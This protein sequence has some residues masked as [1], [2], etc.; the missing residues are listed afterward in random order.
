MKAI[1]YTRTKITYP[2]AR[3]VLE[4]I[5]EIFEESISKLFNYEMFVCYKCFNSGYITLEQLT[6]QLRKEALN[7]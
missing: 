1:N 3:F 2:G 6:I 7:I 4:I 5:V